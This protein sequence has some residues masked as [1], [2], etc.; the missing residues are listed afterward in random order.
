M[1]AGSPQFSV[2]SNAASAVRNSVLQAL[3]RVRRNVEQADIAA[4]TDAYTKMQARSEPDNRS[5]M[6]WS[7]YHGF[8]RNDC[9]HHKGVGGQQFNYDLF[10]PWHRAYLLYFERV[11][12]AENNGAVLPWWDWTSAVSH[13]SGLPAA[14]TS[15]PANGPLHSGPVPPALRANPPRTTR[16][17]GPPSALPTQ[18]AVDA[19]LN[20][21]TTFDDFSSQVQNIHD[22]VHGWTGGDMGVIAASA[23]DP[24]FWSHHCM[25][26]RLWYLW[27]VKYG[28]DNIPPAYLGRTLAPWAL[29]VK[30]VLDT[31]RL[32]Y[33]YGASRVRIS[34]EQFSAVALTRRGQN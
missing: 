21:A 26:D 25:I 22:A 20:G 28:V 5:W 1:A 11:A 6:Y 31:R 14:F 2:V 15:G 23:F 27:Q 4:L 32:G 33:T 12:L 13:Q 16:S 10:L 18:A 8:N 30:D 19:I 17:P 3:V 24:I 29:T 7:E 9:W 34:A